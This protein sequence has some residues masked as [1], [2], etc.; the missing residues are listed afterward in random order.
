M[1]RHA[2][3]L[4]AQTSFPQDFT[5]HRGSAHFAVVLA[6]IVTLA[7]NMLLASASGVTAR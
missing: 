6:Q 1:Q 7:T 2:K 4:A 3:V 5:H